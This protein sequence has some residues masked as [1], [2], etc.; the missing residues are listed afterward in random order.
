RLSS[1]QRSE[2]T[3]SDTRGAAISL[4][5]RIP[6]DALDRFARDLCAA[7]NVQVSVVPAAGAFSLVGQGLG[8]A[9]AP[10]VHCINGL[11]EAGDSVTVTGSFSGAGILVVKDAAL[12]VSGS[13]R[14]EGLIIV[15]GPDVGFQTLGEQNKDILGALI[16]NETG[17]AAGEGAAML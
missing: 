17:F 10:P 1:S 15:T 11:T 13:F 9:G 8:S 14:W 5:D 2:I 3:G 4:S 16:V 7:S 12:R 6:G